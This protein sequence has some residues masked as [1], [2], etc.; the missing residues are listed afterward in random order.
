MA[1]TRGV[2]GAFA[3]A[4]LAASFAWEWRV[5][6]KRAALTARLKLYGGVLQPQASYFAPGSTDE[7]HMDALD[8]GDVL[9]FKR[10]CEAV[11]SLADAARCLMRRRRQR[12]A[13]ASAATAG[14]PPQ[15]FDHCAVVV[16]DPSGSSVPHVLECCSADGRRTLRRY[17]ARVLTS[18]SDEIFVRRLRVERTPALR[19]AV[20]RA[21][22]ALLDES[23]ECS[24]GGSGSGSFGGAADADASAATVARLLRAALPD[25][26]P[27]LADDGA[28]GPCTVAAVERIGDLGGGG[29]GTLLSAPIVIRL[30]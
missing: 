29:D 23:E 24:G 26:V 22:A 5:D 25:R 10:D 1:A 12:E 4:P 14:A 6:A 11:R 7:M 8:S 27:P 13:T 2:A 28:L 3:V 19:A 9:L 17:D 18:S 30:A 16:A 21:A 15:R 20:A